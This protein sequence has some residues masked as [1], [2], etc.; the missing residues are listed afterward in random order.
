MECSVCCDTFDKKMRKPISCEYCH[1]TACHTCAKRYVRDSY[2]A[3]HCMECHKVWSKEFLTHH[4]T[5]TFL[6]GEYRESRETLLFSEEQTHLPNYQD[7]AE[8]TMRL[9]SFDKSINVIQRQIAENDAN[10]NQ[11]VLTQ[12]QNHSALSVSLREAYRKRYDIVTRRVARQNKPFIMK[13]PNECKGFLSDTYVCG[14]CTVSF[15]K[16][17]HGALTEGHT[18]DPDQIATVTELKRSTRPCPNCHIPIYKT[19]GC[20]QMFCIQCKTAFSWR[21]GEIETG[22]IHNPHYYDLLR[23]GNIQFDQQRHRQEHGGCGPIPPLFTIRRLMDGMSGAIRDELFLFHQR[24]V[25]HRNV[26]LPKY[27]Q[28]DNA[29]ID[30]ERVNYLCG[31]L[32]EDKYKAKLYVRYERNQRKLEERQILDSYV[33]IGEELFRSLTR[34]NVNEILQQLNTLRDVTYDAVVSMDKRY[35]HQAFLHPHDIKAIIH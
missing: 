8:R 19:D 35:Q 29:E 17:C 26:D 13:C 6:K 25:H 33:T 32:N 28:A 12:R 16:E 7:E 31:K 21:T 30:K 5:K 24:F 9:E 15:C 22:V 3:P 1:Y 2:Q 27:I 14:L 10:V 20:D 23:Q 18:C 4:F 11:L 34:I